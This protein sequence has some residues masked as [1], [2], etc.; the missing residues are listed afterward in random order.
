[1]INDH[2]VCHVGLGLTNFIKKNF[3]FTLDLYICRKSNNY[4]EALDFYND[5]NYIPTKF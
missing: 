3:F 4:V 1:M 2:L 5:I